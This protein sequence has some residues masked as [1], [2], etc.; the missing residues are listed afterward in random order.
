M[1]TLGNKGKLILTTK[2]SDKIVASSVIMDDNTK[3]A[4]LNL[5]KYTR[6]LL[7]KEPKMNLYGLNSLKNALLTYWNESINPDTEKFWAEIKAENIDY[8]RK[9]PLRF[10]LSKNRF[11]R[12]DQGMD[13][14]KHWIELKKLKGIKANYTTSEIEQIE[15]IISEDEKRRLGILKKCLIKKEITQSQ[16]LKFGECWAYMS[17]CDLWDRYF[18]KDE[19]EELLN[20]WKNFESK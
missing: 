16:Y 13:A 9:E 3:E 10:A 7:I 20:I 2:I 6:D 19:V 1:T 18:R 14:R 17:N 5:S 4:F 15:N 12:V 11:R 8:E